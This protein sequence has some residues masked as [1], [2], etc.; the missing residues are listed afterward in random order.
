[1]A[2]EGRVERSQRGQVGAPCTESI[3]APRNLDRFAFGE[4][5]RFMLRVDERSLELVRCA[6]GMFRIAR[7][8]P[9]VIGENDRQVLGESMG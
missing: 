2:G 6:A 3:D 5:Q 8:G 7:K 9:K 1:V 4:E